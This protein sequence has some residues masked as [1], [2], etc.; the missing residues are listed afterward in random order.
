MLHIFYSHP[1]QKEQR[2]YPGSHYDV[3]YQ[4]HICFLLNAS[5]NSSS[6]FSFHCSQQAQQAEFGWRL[7]A[8]LQAGQSRSARAGHRLP[9]QQ[10]LCSLFHHT[11]PGSAAQ[12]PFTQLLRLSAATE[13]WKYLEDSTGRSSRPNLLAAET[14]VAP[15]EAT[16]GSQHL[17]RSDESVSGYIT[18][19]KMPMFFKMQFRFQVY[20]YIHGLH[21]K[22]DICSTKL[23]FL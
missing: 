2:Y 10:S 14:T 18:L 5:S 12:S 22:E 17:L 13:C 21:T 8:P 15:Q 16:E 4:Q 9:L 7:G 1:A 11:L 23:G 19:S 3:H 20:L 6:S